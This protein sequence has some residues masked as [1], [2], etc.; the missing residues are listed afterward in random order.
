MTFKKLTAMLLSLAMCG[1]VLAACG[2][3]D[4]SSSAIDSSSEVATDTPSSEESVE[5]EP[6]YSWTA[7]VDEDPYADS[8]KIDLSFEAS[9][10][11]PDW[12]TGADKTVD[13]AEGMWVIGCDGKQMQNPLTYEVLAN[14][15][16]I[17]IFYTCDN[18][19]ETMLIHPIF[20]VVKDASDLTN[21]IRQEY[22]ADD[23][24]QYVTDSLAGKDVYSQQ[25]T[26]SGILTIPCEA[27]LAT[28]EEGQWIEQLGVGFTAL[29]DASKF[30]AGSANSYNVSIQGCYLVTDLTEEDITAFV[31]PRYAE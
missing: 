21:M 19:F 20:K 16:A 8:A 5:T 9:T 30:P 29:T 23:W 13:I 4:D 25:L 24:M 10:D 28:L 2:N 7:P 3:D 17:Q 26:T 18:P 22:L 12:A 31:N 27:L 15:T 6:E 14:S 1:A 11:A